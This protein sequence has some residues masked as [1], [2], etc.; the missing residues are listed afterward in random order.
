[1]YKFGNAEL[2]KLKVFLIDVKKSA[3]IFHE[4]LCKISM[5][6]KYLEAVSL[7]LNFTKN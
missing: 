2:L 4:K 3:I 1:M 5:N 7:K 6:G